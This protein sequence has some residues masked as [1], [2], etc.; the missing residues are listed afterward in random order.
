[1]TAQLLDNDSDMDTSDD[2]I[3][4]NNR[5]FNNDNRISKPLYLFN[6]FVNHKSIFLSQKIAPMLKKYFTT[7]DS[8]L[9]PNTLN[10]SLRIASHN[11]NGLNSKGKQLSLIQS[12]NHKHLDILGI[13]DTRL[14]Q[15]NAN[16]ACNSDSNYRT[17][18]TP[19]LPLSVSGGLGLIIHKQY[20]KFVQ[21]VTRWSDRILAIDLYMAGRNKLRIINVY[22]PPLNSTSHNTNLRQDTINETLR[23][24]KDV[25]NSHCI[26]LGD[27]NMDL[28]DFTY[29]AN[30]GSHIP[31]SYNLFSYLRN[32]NFTDSHPIFE[33]YTIPTFVR[34]N[35]S[36]GLPT[37]IS[38]I[39]TIWISSSLCPDILQAETWDTEAF[40]DSDHNMI[41]TYLAKDLLFGSIS[42]A[43]LK[44][45]KIKRKVFA[46]KR[47]DEEKW[48]DF[49]RE[50]DVSLLIQSS[51]FPS[52]TRSSS[53]VSLRGTL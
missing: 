48:S 50:T 25:S 18:W 24:I 52:S 20:S 23:L 7:Q 22:I 28:D 37:S 26:I 3:D 15:K 44:Q 4:T 47:M 5:Q 6:P 16:F 46:Y 14:N 13:C 11:V 41:I 30:Q 34:K 35:A 36:T 40:H 31:S 38:R 49:A 29:K 10:S 33:D 21:H 42:Q 39:D 9:T 45:N 1:M 2:H 43:H 8:A 19:K 53:S 17:F 27:F 32:H 51:K 12:M